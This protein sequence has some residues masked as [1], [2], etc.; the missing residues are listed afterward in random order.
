MI[1]TIFSA[2][3]N[4]LALILLPFLFKKITK[5]TC[6]SK[7]GKSWNPEKAEVLSTFI[8]H[9]KVRVFYLKIFLK[10]YYLSI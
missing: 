9:V 4:I 1:I 5:L 7:T 2:D 6:R 10:Y 8:Y 3:D